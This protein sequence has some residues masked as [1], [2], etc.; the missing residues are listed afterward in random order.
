[1]VYCGKLSKACLPCRKRKLICDLCKDGCSQ[2][3]R[4]NLK[5]SGYRDTKAL[6]VRDETSAVRKKIQGPKS[7][8]SIP[9]VVSVSTCTQAKDV[10]FYNYVVGSSKPFDFLQ[11]LYSPTS[12]DDHLSRSVDAVALAY[13]NYQ[14]RSLDTQVEA[15]QQY[16]MALRLTGAALQ[17]PD[18]AKKDSTVLTILLLDLYEKITNTNPEYDGAWA[19]HLQGALTLVKLRGNHQFNDPNILRML[20]R[21]ST[22]LLISCVASNRPIPEELVALRSTIAAHFVLPPDPKWRESDL[23]IELVRLRQQLKEGDLSD[24]EVIS[25]L[26][27]LDSKFLALS[28]DVTPSWQYQTVLVDKKSI[29]HYERHHHIYRHELMTQM[30]NVLRLTRIGLNELIYSCCSETQD[31]DAIA[32]R[33]RASETITRMASDICASVPQYIGAFP[34][35]FELQMTGREPVILDADTRLSTLNRT[36]NPTHH[37]PCYRLIFPLYVA[38]NSFAAPPSLK[39]WAIKQLRFMADYHGIENAALIVQI[40]ESGEKRDPWLVYAMLGTYAFVC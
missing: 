19:A 39:P 15:R 12:K 33:Y 2:C 36:P 11:S 27:E 20:V 34:E 21:L 24:E 28:M 40:L 13:L 16:I 25:S 29:H 5:C 31:P 32:L 8:K 1:M 23:I 9:R 38:A 22:N 10:F 30:W 26:L 7:T 37:L 6:R 3:S 35:I 17:T 18:L 14:R 4:A